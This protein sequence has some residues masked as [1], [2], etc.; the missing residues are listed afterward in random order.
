MARV[1]ALTLLFIGWIS[2]VLSIFDLQNFLKDVRVLA[3]MKELQAF[4]AMVRRQMYLS[5]FQLL[6]FWGVALSILWGMLVEKWSTPVIAIV[7]TGVVV[8]IG[9]QKWRSKMREELWELPASDKGIGSLH[10]AVCVQWAS[11]ALPDF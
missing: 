6:I 9:F 11:K 5:M 2:I 3:D 1:L 4:K 10:Q 7:A 8:S